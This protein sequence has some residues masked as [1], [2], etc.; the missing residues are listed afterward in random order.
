MDKK[1]K[2][3]DLSMFIKNKKSN[4][5]S[6]DKSNYKSNDNSIDL[7][8]YFDNKLSGGRKKMTDKTKLK[9]KREWYKKNATKGKNVKEYNKKYYEEH[10]GKL[11]LKRQ[12]ENK[13]NYK[14]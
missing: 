2:S 10:K 14:E 7:T 11:K 12:S 6:N 1:N 5:K 4:D 13:K 3:L 9:Y 8:K